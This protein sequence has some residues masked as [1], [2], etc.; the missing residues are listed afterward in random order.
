MHKLGEG[1]EHKIFK[2]DQHLA[3]HVKYNGAGFSS[4]HPFLC[5]QIITPFLIQ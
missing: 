3:R 2:I 1:L 5:S 4:S